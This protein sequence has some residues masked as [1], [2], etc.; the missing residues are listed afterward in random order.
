MNCNS[1]YIIYLRTYV[2]NATYNTL[3]RQREVRRFKDRL[4][5]H[6]QYIHE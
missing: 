5:D 3:V 2:K 6:I 1:R 4:N